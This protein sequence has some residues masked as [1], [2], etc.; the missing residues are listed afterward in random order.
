M[1][2]Q[3][4]PDV[5]SKIGAL[6]E[7]R[8]LIKIE[9]KE[10]SNTALVNEFSRLLNGVG[11]AMSPRMQTMIFRP[12]SVVPTTM[13]ITYARLVSEIRPYKK[14]THQVR[15]IAIGSPTIALTTSKIL[16]NSVIST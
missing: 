2:H 13:K 7:Y 8:H 11:K 10:V 5:D 3:M 1:V 12:K 15:M 9:E 16:F 4:A 14:E 6:L